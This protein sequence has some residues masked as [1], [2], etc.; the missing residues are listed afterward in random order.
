MILALMMLTLYDMALMLLTLYDAGLDDAGLDDADFSNAGLG[1][2]ALMML[3]LCFSWTPRTRSFCSGSLGSR[4]RCTFWW[5]TP[6]SSSSPTDC[7]K[8][9]GWASALLF[10][11]LH[12]AVPACRGGVFIFCLPTGHISMKI[13]KAEGIRTSLRFR[14]FSTSLRL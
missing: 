4:P 3:T 14:E 1:V 9:S 13:H 10:H 7:P 5:S 11:F 12:C 6:W 2:L 8:V